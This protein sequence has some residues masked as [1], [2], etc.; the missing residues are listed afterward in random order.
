M[1]TEQPHF[2][3]RWEHGN[4]PVW[5][6]PQ[7]NGRKTVI[8]R[9]SHSE[10]QEFA[11]ARQFFLTL[12]NGRDHKLTMSR[13]FRMSHPEPEK[14]ILDIFTRP[15]LVLVPS[16][17]PLGIDLKQRGHEVAKLLYAGF[18][19]RI[20]RSGFDPREVLQEVYR[21]LLARNRGRCPWDANKSSFSHYVHM[22]CSCVLNNYHKR[23]YRRRGREVDVDDSTLFLLNEAGQSTEKAVSE[24][25]M[26][27][28]DLSKWIRLR[29]KGLTSTERIEIA[30]SVVPLLQ[31]GMT[32]QEM[33]DQLGLTKG[34]VNRAVR[35]VREAARS[36][37]EALDI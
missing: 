10:L 7:E 34:Q 20:A 5:I 25:T 29:Y 24:D 33:A 15:S 22:V 14:T 31:D 8:M 21:G 35:L 16:T 9:D 13:Y 3:T 2:F 27:V 17:M 30:C 1:V 6:K 19:A 23:E 12:Y 26:A 11:S 28:Q 36:W 37:K 4:F 18:G 32:R